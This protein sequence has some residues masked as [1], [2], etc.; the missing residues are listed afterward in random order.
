MR[1]PPETVA[2]LVAE[3]INAAF[4]EAPAEDTSVPYVD[5]LALARELRGVRADLDARMER[6]TASIQASAAELRKEAVVPADVP[7]MA[8]GELFDQ[9]IDVLETIGGGPAEDVRGRAE[10]PVS[11]VCAPG[12]RLLSLS[13]AARAMGGGSGQLGELVVAAVNAALD[14]LEAGQL[15]RREESGAG[16]EQVMA[17]ID[18][19]R[20]LSVLRMRAYAQ[21]VAALM[22]GIQPRA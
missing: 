3:A 6:V 16:S 22:A 2:G 20:E 1:E 15:R 8:F 21:G 7:T 5:P 19:L 10:G 13:V 18:E 11:V 14:D 12:P 9:L 4:G 17:R